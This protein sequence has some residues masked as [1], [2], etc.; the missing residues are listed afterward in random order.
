MDTGECHRPFGGAVSAGILSCAANVGHVCNL[1]RWSLNPITLNPSTE[2]QVDQKASKLRRVRGIASRV[3]FL[4]L[5]MGLA[6]GLGLWQG[7][8]SIPKLLSND[9]V[10]M[11][12]AAVQLRSLSFVLPFCALSDMMEST[13]TASRDYNAVLAGDL[14]TPTSQIPEF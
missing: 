14:Q 7:S 2:F 8:K 12:F 11:E 10:V 4:G 5:C 3:A 1:R 6:G 13:L 9:P